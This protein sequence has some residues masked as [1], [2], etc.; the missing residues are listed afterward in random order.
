ML[1]HSLTQDEIARTWAPFVGWGKSRPQD[2]A[3]AR[4]PVFIGVPGR[5]FW[6]PAALRRLPGMVLQDDRPHE[7]AENIYW[8]GNR[9][10]AAQVL[11]AYESAWL[12]KALLEPQ[13]RR[14]LVDALIRASNIWPIS[15]HSNKGLGGA[16]AEAI[17][18]TRETATNPQVLDAFALVICAAEEQPTYP[19]IPDHEPNVAESCRDAAGVAAAMAEIYRL[20]P[21]AGA[22]VSESNYFHKYWKT[23]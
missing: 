17:A 1:C 4:D 21:D 11:H 20:A 16:S 3:F 19:G 15:L 18:A 13:Q 14:Q 8:A 10:E 12:P 23:A 7:P 9:G 22:Y 6:D 5:A 2:F